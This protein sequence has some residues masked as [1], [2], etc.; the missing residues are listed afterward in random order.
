MKKKKLPGPRFRSFVKILTD[1]WWCVLVRTAKTEL[2]SF[3]KV[4]KWK[5]KTSRERE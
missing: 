4:N 5:K 1:R 2:I 3:K